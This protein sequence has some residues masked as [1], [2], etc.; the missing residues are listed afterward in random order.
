MA[1]VI[2]GPAHTSF[3]VDVGKMLTCVRLIGVGYENEGFRILKGEGP[4]WQI[5]RELHWVNTV[6]GAALLLPYAPDKILLPIRP[7]ELDEN[8]K[9][10]DMES[11][12]THLIWRLERL[13]KEIS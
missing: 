11:R 3:I 2:A 5:D 10:A 7:D 8:H 1:L 4:C 9:E 6:T 12:A 13:K